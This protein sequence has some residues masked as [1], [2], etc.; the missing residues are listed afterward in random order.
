[1]AKLIAHWDFNGGNDLSGNGHNLVGVNT[2]ESPMLLNRDRVLYA[3]SLTSFVNGLTVLIE[4]ST[5]NFAVGSSQALIALSRPS[6]GGELVFVEYANNKT[7]GLWANAEISIQPFPQYISRKNR[8]AIR[9]TKDN[10]VSFKFDNGKGRPD[11]YAGVNVRSTQ[12]F[13]IGGENINTGANNFFEGSIYECL[14]YEGDIT[15]NEIDNY[16]LYGQI[17]AGGLTSKNIN[18]N[19]PTWSNRETRAQANPYP[20][21]LQTINRKDTPILSAKTGNYLSL[22]DQRGKQRPMGYYQ[23][24]VLINKVPTAN[25]RVMCFTNHGQLRDETR[26]DANG[27]YR[28]DHLDLNEKYMFVAQHDDGDPNTAPEYSA[29]A[30]DWQSPK[31]YK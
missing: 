21:Q 8:L 6:G 15:N 4:Y 13:S 26:S 11:I 20:S 7:L 9:L 17:I 19:K 31:P 1:M 27:I 2:D 18:I 22:F 29:V 3:P 14:L 10:M 30:A 12:P 23:S 28:F 24:T 16:L 25:R 5:P